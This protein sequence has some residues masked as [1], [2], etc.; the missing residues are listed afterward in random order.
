MSKIPVAIQLELAD[1]FRKIFISAGIEINDGAC[2]T[3]WGIK[4][5]PSSTYL[6]TFALISLQLEFDR[7]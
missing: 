7:H 1:E 5:K 6:R 2:S 4:K 3:T